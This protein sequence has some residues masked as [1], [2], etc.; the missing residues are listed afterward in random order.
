[1]CIYSNGNKIG[2]TLIIT[3]IF[4]SVYSTTAQNCYVKLFNNSGFTIS[5]NIIEGRSCEIINMIPISHRDSFMIYVAGLYSM[6][7]YISEGNSSSLNELEALASSESKYYILY[8]IVFNQEATIPMSI[9]VFTNLPNVAPF[10]CMNISNLALMDSQIEVNIGLPNSI[11]EYLST[12][13]ENTI[14]LFGELFNENCCIVV[15]DDIPA[16]LRG[17]GFFAYP[18]KVQSISTF[19][20]NES[21]IRQTGVT[22]N[23]KA[24][25]NIIIDEE[26]FDIGSSYSSEVWVPEE[27][28]NIYI[29]KNENICDTDEFGNIE[30]LFFNDVVN[31]KI[32][33]HIYENQSPSESDS[34]YIKWDSS[35]SDYF[36]L[37]YLR[38]YREGLP[39]ELEQPGDNKIAEVDV[40]GFFKSLYNSNINKAGIRVAG[41]N[42]IYVFND[43]PHD[44][45]MAYQGVN[46][47][48]D[49]I[50]FYGTPFDENCMPTPFCFFYDLVWIDSV[51]T[52]KQITW[53]PW[54]IRH[55]YAAKYSP[56]DSIKIE[57]NKMDFTASTLHYPYRMLGCTDLSRDL[58]NE[59]ISHYYIR[60]DINLPLAFNMYDFGNYL[61]GGASRLLGFSERSALYWANWN[62]RKSDRGGDSPSDQKAIKWGYRT[63]GTILGN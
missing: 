42:E 46:N 3:M 50:G 18:V 45:K 8:V 2:K 51:Y 41:Y 25:L 7:R 21:G 49:Y 29:T 53:Q 37:N 16:I 40:D 9:K 4:I 36:G 54:G 60:P 17:R 15:S 43:Q 57:G 63:S 1:M 47:M 56:Q 11:N 22:L 13:L 10:D 30:D 19:Q 5:E 44:K 33:F 27:S 58:K 32:W 26:T 59:Q 6:T 55:L 62:E 14:S 12:A 24:N 20:S 48:I 52:S 31:H 38:Y 35:E 61:W 39:I 34:L 28:F 23:D